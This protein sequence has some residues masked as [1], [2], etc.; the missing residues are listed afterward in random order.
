MPR[1]GLNVGQ[2][3]G[4][5]EMS[6][7]ERFCLRT[8]KMHGKSGKEERRIMQ[9]HEEQK[10]RKLEEN[11]SSSTSECAPQSVAASSSSSSVEQ[12]SQRRK[13]IE[14]EKTKEKEKAAKSEVR[15]PA[16]LS[17]LE[18]LRAEMGTAKPGKS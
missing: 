5:G 14:Q 18:S 12:P 16:A 6:K 1:G 10:K 17:F 3:G 13:F 7:R 2:L 4:S 11:A 15:T 9:I 8:G